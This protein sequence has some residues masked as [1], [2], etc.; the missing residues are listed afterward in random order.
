MYSRAIARTSLKAI[1]RP[2]VGLTGVRSVATPFSLVN[3][4]FGPSLSDLVSICL[5]DGVLC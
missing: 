2:A 3:Q 5:F 4:C 1:V